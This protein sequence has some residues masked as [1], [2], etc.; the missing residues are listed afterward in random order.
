M[1]P[2]TPITNNNKKATPS[3]RLLLSV[4]S[5][6]LLILSTLIPLNAAT[7]ADTIINN[8][9]TANF[10]ID[11]SI[12][13]LNASVSITTDSR[14]P[15]IISFHRITDKGEASN[16]QPA[17]YNSGAT[18]GKL[19]LPLDN[20]KLVTG[21]KVD[22]NKPIKTTESSQFLANDPIVI[23]VT[24]YDQ[25]QD[26]NKR[27]TVFVTITIP[28]T[29]DQETILLTETG[30]STGIFIGAVETNTQSKVSFDGR[31]N[32]ERGAKLTVTYNDR[33]DRNDIS[34]TAA[35][36]DPLGTINLAKV[37]DKKEASIG[38][39]V[40][41][42]ITL[43]NSNIKTTLKQVEIR[44]TLP[45]GFRYQQGSA[46]LNGKAFTNNKVSI[47]GRSLVF[48]IGAVPSDL[49]NGWKINYRTKVGINAPIGYAVNQAQAFSS[50]DTSSIATAR[51][52]IADK[53]MTNTTL[54]TG[55]VY[56]GCKSKKAL[57]N[58][59]LY[60]E[61]GR[62]VLSD[63]DGFWH[64]E[65][66]SQQAHVIQLDTDSLPAGYRAINCEQ[67]NDNTGSALSKFIN[68]KTLWRADFYVEKS[69]LLTD[70]NSGDKTNTKTKK[71]DPLGKFNKAFANKSKAGF[72][73]LW[74]PHNYVPAVASTKIAVKHSSQHKIKVFLNNKPVSMLNYDGSASNKARTV[75]IR[76][77]RGV[78]I[79][80]QQRDNILTVI[81]L[82]KSGKEIDKK[83]QTIHFS[84]KPA[85]VEYLAKDSLLIADGKTSPIIT[86]RIKDEDGFP[87]RANMHGYF[88]FKNND[89]QIAQ[90]DQD[91]LDE[92]GI[93]GKYKFH[94]KQGGLAQI[95]LTPTSR[96]GQ[97]SLDIFLADKTETINVWLKPKLRNWILVGIAEGTWAH[98]KLS[99]NMRTLKDKG[100]TEN[101]Q[102]GRIALVAKGR[103]KGNYL[104]TLAYDSA[105][106]QGNPDNENSAEL[107]G[108]IDPDAWYTVY[109]DKSS[110]QYET[111]SASKL[112]L[113]LEKDQF[114]ALFGDYRTG[115]TVTELSR[116]ERALN[117]IHSEYHNE[118]V[119]YNVFASHTEKRHQR[120]E[121]AGDGTSGLYY[122]SRSIVQNSE[123]ISIETRDQFDRGKV[124]TSRKLTRHKDYDIDY[125]SRTLFFKFPI[126]GRDK[127]LNANF[128]IVDYE[129]DDGDKKMLTAGGRAAIKF[130]NG[131]AEAGLTLI[132]EG[133]NDNST[134]RLIGFDTT[135]KPTDDLEVKG[136]IAQ[137]QT[138]GNS[139]NIKG[140]AW[141]LEAKKS[142]TKSETSA[143]I[144][145]QEGGF[146]LGQQK[147]SEQGSQ[148]IGIDSRYKLDA[149]TQLKG[150]LSQEKNLQRGDT[151]QRL[152]IE[153][154]KKFK[155]GNLSLGARHSRN[156]TSSESSQTTALLLGGTLST[157]D[158]KATLH[159]K[160]E[161]NL[162]GNN[163]TINDPD[164]AT[165]GI[166][167][168]VTDKVSLFAEHEVSD[169]GESIT[170][171]SRVGISSPL[172]EGAKVKTSINREDQLDK[173]MVYAMVGLSQ[174]VKLSD[175]LIVD[176]TLDHATTIDSKIK[177][178]TATE[179]D[180]PNHGSTRDDYIATTLAYKWKI[181][182]WS[183]LGRIELRD[184]DR[185]DKINLKLELDHKIADGK[186]LN[187]KIKSL[188]AKK[189]NGDQHQQTT[190]SMGA[191]WQ[192]F[193]ASYSVLE[194]LDYI[195]ESDTGK[196]LSKHTRKLINNIH[197]N[198]Q[199]DKFE[200]GL[201]HGI[202]HI[203]AT[204]DA[205]QKEN[206]TIDVGLIEAKYKLDKLW[207]IGA[208]AG[209]S[210]DWENNNVE[211][212]AGVSVSASPAKNTK[213]SLGYN[214]AGF[215]DNEFDTSGY[216]AEGFF[217]QILYKFDQESLQ[218]NE[219]YSRKDAE[220]AEKK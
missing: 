174:H 43:H 123:I 22:F 65:G 170:Q 184:G 200:I 81:L 218:L 132:H 214:F 189:D 125:N 48:T 213:I 6:L 126:S 124:L 176:F 161:K 46:S 76:R 74:P 143:Y 57:K 154:D 206:S 113:K 191:A 80:T 63:A 97:V 1:H 42:E 155:R 171:S 49:G 92:S 32:V 17:A 44:D 162:A 114:Y 157:K 165:L 173:S 208:H 180:I 91:A 137:S 33:A 112:F 217:T 195:D 152:S 138:K 27:E 105:K 4:I 25:N 149:K 108:N 164:R 202:Q 167:V 9:A 45:V 94:I 201:H 85:A 121:I 101:Y 168:A 220:S 83:T 120:D 3:L 56:L 146:G 151:T 116:Y 34:A 106:K 100:V 141:L 75:I 53:L 64:M 196:R 68:S 67:N 156:K 95:K 210:R 10:S 98:Q 23:H 129:T 21:K 169:N 203:L 35:L 50:N 28:E 41:Y 59:R 166:D 89:Y 8:T 140:K 55:R 2:L 78:D 47:N 209:Y 139:Q 86:M 99:G 194:R 51:V 158:K 93:K 133:N 109:A 142:T 54:I 15:S 186:R 192:P 182:D 185:E 82:N 90:N 119:S 128:I 144:R 40:S 79:N 71:I 5:T 148:K 207:S 115:L 11:G 179:N 58:V 197:L 135:Y 134:G 117:G 13:T 130:D 19:W 163:H 111:A 31:F 145:Q 73:I 127:N 61:T 122:L 29:G 96:S 199:I 52:K 12:E 193:D 24:D 39:L 159:G 60:L 211:K 16:I 77:W 150:E 118:K 136:E 103:V 175:Q 70:S 177:Q 205:E 62:S 30:L 87:M 181:D 183:T 110:H 69:K 172:W 147:I 153:A 18:G 102:Q 219:Q 66:L 160:L 212:V 216:T 190:I 104:L 131:K 198:K 26:P 178:S 215:S 38:D 84:G 187:A 7:L 20:L 72:E 88:S 107:E 36:I 14:T 204:N 37:A 188:H